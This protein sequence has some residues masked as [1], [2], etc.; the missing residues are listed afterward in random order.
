MTILIPNNPVQEAHFTAGQAVPE[1]ATGCGNPLIDP[2][3]RTITYL[4]VSVTDRCDFRC[5][6][7]MAENMTFLPRKEL[8]T[9]EETERLCAAFIRRGV[10]RIRITGGEPLTRRNIIR[11]FAALGERLRAGALDEVTL[12][13]NGSQLPTHA[14]DLYRHG[15]RRINISL[16]TLDAERFRA[17]SRWGRL[18][19]VLAGIEAAR[20]AGLKIKL[21]TVAMRGASGNE[22]E[23]PR[24]IEWAHE[25]D[26]DISLIET[27]PLGEVAEDRFEKYLPLS[28]VRRDLE[29]RW[30]LEEIPH[31]TAGPSR[32]VR[33][34]E[35]GGRLGFITPLSRNFCGG[36]NRV[37]VTCTGRIFMCLGQDDSA[38]LRAPLRAG[39]EG[40]TGMSEEERDRLLD[41][42]ITAAIARKPFGHD[43]AI[44][45]PGLR[46]ALARH[47]STTGG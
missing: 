42:A 30:R 21:N 28:E 29:A 15:V 25:R 18:E 33:V 20:D 13:T 46:P 23:I 27:M 8:L 39:L 34:R 1:T 17:I 11:L 38:D 47:M 9:L 12:T 16:D 7:C 41:A 22:T 40:E 14:A 31:R 3:G 4:R 35:T 10:R 2:F 37:R 24:L 36:C 32:Y 26:M 43:F 5:V 44:D 19:Q 45:R 6:Y